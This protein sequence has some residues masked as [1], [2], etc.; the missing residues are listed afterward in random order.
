M[1]Y[2][3]SEKSIVDSPIPG[4][5]SMTH[6]DLT[7]DCY[8]RRNRILADAHRAEWWMVIAVLLLIAG[9]GFAAFQ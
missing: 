5:E 3:Q 4:P 8:K 6:N 7:V 9:M 1:S 2:S